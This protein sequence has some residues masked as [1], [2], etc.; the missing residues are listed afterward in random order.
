[1]TIRVSRAEGE[2]TEKA[3]VKA[4]R[5]GGVPGPPKAPRQTAAV[6]PAAS[7][8]GMSGAGAREVAR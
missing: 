5:Q 1:M 4:T 8:T 7:R 6:N 3:G 2:A